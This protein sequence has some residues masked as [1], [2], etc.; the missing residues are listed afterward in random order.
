LSITI[1]TYN[2]ASLSVETSS[3]VGA[4]ME[5]YITVST[6]N[7]A[8]LPV[9]TSGAPTLP[10]WLYDWRIWLAILLIILVLLVLSRRKRT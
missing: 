7:E 6:Y 8:S 5:T 10:S 9:E 3:T 4:P 2:E 1:A